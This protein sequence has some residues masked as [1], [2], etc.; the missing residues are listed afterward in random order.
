M[1]HNEYPSIEDEIKAIL[2][3]DSRSEFEVTIPIKPEDRHKFKSRSGD[4]YKEIVIS[5]SP[6]WI[7]KVYIPDLTP[8]EQEKRRKAICKAAA[9]LLR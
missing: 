6:T 1:K 2:E 8:E 9:D 5:K 7:V 3:D 4:T